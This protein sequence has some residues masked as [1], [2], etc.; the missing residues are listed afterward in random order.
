MTR[1]VWTMTP[2]GGPTASDGQ[3]GVVEMI[4]GN[5]FWPTLAATARLYEPSALR[6]ADAIGT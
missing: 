3:S 1:C 2:A 4:A 6:A 5:W